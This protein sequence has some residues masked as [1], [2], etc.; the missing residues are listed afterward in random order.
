MDAFPE[1]S[2][3]LGEWQRDPG[4]G[5]LFESVDAVPNGDGTITMRYRTGAGVA[6]LYF[7]VALE[8]D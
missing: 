8:R 5:S 4:D 3:T 6:R 2:A 1:M 7:R